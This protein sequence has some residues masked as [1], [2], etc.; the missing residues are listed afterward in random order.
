MS[1]NKTEKYG[2]HAWVA[3]DDFSRMEINENFA[4]LDGAA[5][6][7][8][9]G[10]Y[11]GE[12]PEYGGTARRFDLGMRPQ[13]VIVT[14]AEG[15]GIGSGRYFSAMAGPGH[16]AKTGL[17]LDESG[18]SVCNEKNGSILLNLSGYTYYYLALV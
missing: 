5:V 8:V 2:L 14:A 11:V 4:L 18:F 15:F 6:R 16:P 17:V 10:S 3:G 9:F 7:M 1:T 12:L 13:V